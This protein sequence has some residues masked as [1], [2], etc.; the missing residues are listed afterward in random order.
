MFANAAEQKKVH[1]VAALKG[2]VQSIA[3]GC[4]AEHRSKFVLQD[5]LRLLNIV[6]EHTNSGGEETAT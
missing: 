2:F 3:L 6:F 1:V 4:R 5:S